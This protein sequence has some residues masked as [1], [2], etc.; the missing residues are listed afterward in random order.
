MYCSCQRFILTGTNKATA[1]N[2]ALLV[3]HFSHT[4]LVSL[5]S[6][7]LSLSPPPTHSLIHSHTHSYRYSPYLHHALPFSLH[8]PKSLP[9]VPQISLHRTLHRDRDDA[10]RAR[11]RVRAIFSAAGARCGKAWIAWGGT[12]CGAHACMVSSLVCVC[13]CVCVYV[14]VYVYVVCAYVCVF[15]VV[16]IV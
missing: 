2:T 13:V 4:R 8:L 6:S 1:S 14:Y 12:V 3:P 9:K 10:S 7:S 5:I 11:V 16:V 15:C